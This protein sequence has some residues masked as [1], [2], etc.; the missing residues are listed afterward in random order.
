MS[1]KTILAGI[2]CAALVSL[3]A[4][5]RLADAAMNGDRAA[6]ASL[7]P[8][9]V[10]VNAAQGDGTTALH[11]AAY[12]DDLE[13]V[14]MLLAAGANAK[15]ATR[16]GSITPLFMACQNGDAAIIEALLK[17]GADANAPKSNGTTPLM[18]AAESGSAAA[19]RVLVEHGANVGSKESVHG[20][21]ALMFA[22]AEGREA[23]IKFLLA[24][25]ADANVATSFHKLEHV[26]Y[27]QDGNIV[28]D[29]PKAGA[30]ATGPDA[31]NLEAFAHSIGLESAVYA[32]D[33]AA[34][35]HQALDL[36][37]HTIGFKA[38]VFDVDNARKK[39]P[40]AGDISNRPPRKI[41]PDFMGGM[42]ALLYASREGHLAA[43][44]A[45]VEGG[46]NVN[47]VSEGEKMSP[48]VEAIINGHLDIAKYLLDRGAD[49]KLATEAGL[50]AL[51][52]A[53]DVQ[54]APKAWFPQPSVDQEKTG[55]LGLMKELIEKGADVNAQIGE[56][57]WFRAFTNDYTW[58]DT[59]GATAF[60]RAAQSSD[61][62]AMKLLVE[63]GADP[64]LAN[65]AGETPLLAASGIGW[66][67]NW[68]QRAPYPIVDAVKFCVEHGNDVNAADSRGY[69]A[70]HGA[71]FLGDNDTVSYLVSQG[72]KVDAKSKAGDSPADMAN[73]PTRFGQPHAETVALLEKLGSPN[74]HN[75]RS[76]QCVVAAKA[77]IY[78][79][80]M[81]PVDPV[82]KAELE[83][84]AKAAGFSEANYHADGSAQP[85]QGRGGA[86]AAA[87]E[88][89]KP[90]APGAK[91]PAKGP[92]DR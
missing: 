87:A 92:G 76:D 42:S 1:T 50:T 53:E 24:H 67:W 78:S 69:T 61:L 3:A 55:Y 8:Q 14:K 56:K 83:A 70:L 33:A 35:E 45:L 27:D 47:Q 25:G 88:P 36:F 4:D 74:S 31:E 22:A 38:A 15:A 72:A 28:E 37:A 9:K 91:P 10:D 16:E 60:W 2:C 68:S 49:P 29:R 12:R 75:C 6:V 71:G 44:Q 11:W 48:L 90:A 13:M 86:M 89:A 82:A 64:K 52:A 54:W 41:G 34:A 40:R 80:R 39:G 17:A 7:L 58:V 77:N 65:K 46:A 21:T 51:Y 59:A 73:G 81:E 62:P 18:I 23:V 66:A 79:D 85:R 63:H 5:T 20:Q 32:A 43:V 84:F 57:L 30:A 26:R 19:V